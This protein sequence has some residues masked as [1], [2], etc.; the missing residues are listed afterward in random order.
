[1]RSVS[2]IVA[3]LILAG[4]FALAAEVQVKVV[5]PNSAPILGAEVDLLPAGDEAPIVG[6][7]SAAGVSVFNVEGKTQ[8]RL[9]V[10]APGFAPYDGEPISAAQFPVVVQLR[11]APATQTVVVTATRNPV[12]TDKTAANVETLAGAQIETMQPV[13]AA[14]AIR[15]LP[16]AVVNTSGQRGGLGSVFVRG[17]DSRYNK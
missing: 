1:M 3:F 13:S 6:T 15:F 7:T 12:P 11:V 17:G 14:D 5:D 10:L 8:Y 4:T 2:E 16:G 9:R